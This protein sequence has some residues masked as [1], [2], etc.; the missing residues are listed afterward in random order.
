MSNVMDLSTPEQRS[1]PNARKGGGFS[2][3]RALLE[4]SGNSAVEENI[5]AH[6]AFVYETLLANPSMDIRRYRINPNNPAAV[7]MG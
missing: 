1:R 6:L 7:L 2:L 5:R 3:R 4:Q